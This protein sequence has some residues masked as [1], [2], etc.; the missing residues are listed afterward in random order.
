MYNNNNNNDNNNIYINIHIYIY[1]NKTEI[2]LH[3]KLLKRDV[4]QNF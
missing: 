3:S 1:G 4:I 2:G